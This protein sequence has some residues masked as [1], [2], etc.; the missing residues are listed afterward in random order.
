LPYIGALP[1]LA[2]SAEY[3]Q[4]V[5]VVEEAG[6]AVASVKTGDLV[7]ATFA[8]QDSTCVFCSEGFQTAC[9]HGGWYGAAE[10]GGS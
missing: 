6:A 10:N 4:L 7:I 5:G 8:F 2:G 9:V 3:G 1:G